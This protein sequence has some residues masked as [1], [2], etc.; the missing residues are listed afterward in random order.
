[1]IFLVKEHTKNYCVKIFNLLKVKW[2]KSNVF[3]FN[4]ALVM[5]CAVDNVT[6]IKASNAIL[7]MLPFFTY[8][9][10]SLFLVA[11]RRIVTF[12]FHK[13]TIKDSVMKTKRSYDTA[14]KSTKSIKLVD[15]N[16]PNHDKNLISWMHEWSSCL[17]PSC[18]QP[19]MFT[20]ILSG[21]QLYLILTKIFFVN[22]IQITS[23][24]WC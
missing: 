15:K 10:K 17:N 12:S 8:G 24:K 21:S 1:M 6:T 11:S 23:S 16:V 5:L 9:T 3:S 14:V 20:C 2:H 18:N 22:C 4:Q 13:D 7:I 19:N